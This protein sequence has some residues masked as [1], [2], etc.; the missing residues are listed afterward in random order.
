MIALDTNVLVRLF[1]NEPSNNQSNLVRELVKSAKVVYI[2]QVV[3]VELIWVLKRAYKISKAEILLILE[4]MANHSSYMLENKAQFLSAL[5]KYKTGNADFPDY[6]I[7][8]N[9]QSNH[10]QLW[11]FDKKLAKHPEVALLVQH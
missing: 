1:V 6:L 2:S 3:Q 10:Y 11:T 8:S 9:C 4:S 7:L 5:Q